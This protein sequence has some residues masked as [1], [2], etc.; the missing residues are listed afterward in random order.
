VDADE[1]SIYLFGASLGDTV[2]QVRY[3]TH[4][5]GVTY[6]QLSSNRT[7]IAKSDIKSIHDKFKRDLTDIYVPRDM[8]TSSAR[9]LGRI[10]EVQTNLYNLYVVGL[11]VTIFSSAALVAVQTK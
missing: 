11:L 1:S 2:S 5:F 3:E 8:N 9:N 10:A 7:K 6:E 4:D